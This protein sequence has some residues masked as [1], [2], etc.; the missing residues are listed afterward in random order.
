[1]K[2]FEIIGYAFVAIVLILVAAVIAGPVLLTI[3]IVGA[4]GLYVLLGWAGIVAL[5]VLLIKWLAK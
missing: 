3:S 4:T 1:M 2:F 5:I